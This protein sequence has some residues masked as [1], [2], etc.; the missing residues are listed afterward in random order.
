M[1]NFIKCLIKNNL[2]KNGKVDIEKINRDTG[3]WL[4]GKGEIPIYLKEMDE[5]NPA[6]SRYY[7][8]EKTFDE[9]KCKEFE[10]ELEFFDFKS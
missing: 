3:L 9:T 7:S 4:Q 2:K 10:K 8:K 1:L 6:F 5:E